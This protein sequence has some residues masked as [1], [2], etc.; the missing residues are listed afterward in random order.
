MGI[1]RA[2]YA[3]IVSDFGSEYNFMQL[4][5]VSMETENPTKADGKDRECLDPDHGGSTRT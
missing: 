2:V 1:T 3:D 5:G 4:T